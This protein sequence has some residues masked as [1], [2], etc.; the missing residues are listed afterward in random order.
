M[1]CTEC[2]HAADFPGYVYCSV[3]KRRATVYSTLPKQV[4]QSVVV[5]KIAG[6]RCHGSK[7]APLT[8]HDLCNGCD[9]QHGTSK[10]TPQIKPC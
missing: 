2:A 5:H 1:I 6:S 10:N 7:R 3:C 9:C 4:N 8:G